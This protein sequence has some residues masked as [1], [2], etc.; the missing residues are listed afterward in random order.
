MSTLACVLILPEHCEGGDEAKDELDN[1]H[2][3]RPQ[4]PA[5]HHWILL[6]HME[7]R[8]K[9]TLRDVDLQEG[10][11]GEEGGE[12]VDGVGDVDQAGRRVLQSRSGFQV[13]RV[14]VHQQ[15]PQNHLRS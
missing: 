1:G 11:G 10:H 2:H 14:H 3:N 8:L 7:L 13:G 4:G 9:K 6:L 15:H 5:Q 12:D